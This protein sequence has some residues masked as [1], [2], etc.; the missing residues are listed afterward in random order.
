MNS[1]HWP[2]EVDERFI[3]HAAFETLERQ[4]VQCNRQS[5]PSCRKRREVLR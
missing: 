4:S 1:H 3:G 5:N 2:E